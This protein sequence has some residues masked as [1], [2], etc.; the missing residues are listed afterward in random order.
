M[1]NFSVCALFKNESDCIKEWIEHYLFHGAEHFYLLDDESDDEYYKIIEK[2]VN[3][4]IITLIKISWPRHPNRQAEI[5]DHYMLPLLHETQWLLIC[6][7][8]EFMWSPAHVDLKLILVNQCTE[9]AEIQV[10]Q[11]LFG[12]NNHI[13][14]PASLVK[15]FTKRR[16]C[17]YGTA[18][19]NGYKYFINSKYPFKKLSVH[20]AIPENEYDEKKRWLVLD[21]RYFIL[22][23]YSCQSKEYFLKKC[24]KTDVNEFKTLTIDDFP[25][26]D[27][28]ET[29]DTRLYEQNKSIIDK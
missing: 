9:L 28:N 8:D 22:N 14:Q 18:R 6:D 21:D 26:F 24:S 5:Y 4:G 10:V 25:E 7:L 19:T 23:H 15:S 1:Y 11:T 27:I 13:T 12:S 16:L 20:F 17:Q 29:E 3:D 2:Y